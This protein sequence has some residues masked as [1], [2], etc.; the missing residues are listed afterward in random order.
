MPVNG[1]RHRRFG[2]YV[3]DDNYRKP[4]D[5]GKGTTGVLGHHVV[6]F[7][8]PKVPV[9]EFGRAHGGAEKNIPKAGER[10]FIVCA[11]KRLNIP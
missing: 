10:S 8:D 3:E 1:S 11:A 2:G 5:L 9:L 7:M 6:M 4:S